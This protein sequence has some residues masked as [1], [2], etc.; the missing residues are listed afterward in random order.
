[1]LPTIA[2]LHRRGT[3]VIHPSPSFPPLVPHGHG[4]FAI[5]AVKR[6]WS[7]VWRVIRQ[8][9]RNVT[10]PIDY[11]KCFADQ[12]NNLHKIERIYFW[13]DDNEAIPE[14]R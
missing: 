9:V 12:S 14:R 4:L 5:V 6:K 1:M 3:P 10:D 7:L 8:E 2:E 13:R 11:R